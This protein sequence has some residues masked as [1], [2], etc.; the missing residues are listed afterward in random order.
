MKDFWVDIPEKIKNKIP[1]LKALLCPS[2][3]FFKV[4][5]PL[6]LL[7]LVL[8]VALDLGTKKIVTENLNF[9]LSYDQYQSFMEGEENPA[10]LRDILN[11]E[12][13]DQL[14]ILG[15]KGK[16]LKFRLIFNDR[17]IFGIG[18]NLPYL[19]FSLSLLATLFLLL[20]RWFNP[21]FA[22]PVAW[23]FIFSGALGNL[24]DKMFIKS[25]STREWVF[26]LAPQKGYVSGVVDFVESIW[27]G[28]QGF[29]SI[30]LLRFLS[31]N[32]WP[33]FNLADS[34]ISIGLVFLLLTTHKTYKQRSKKVSK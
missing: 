33:N 7:F 9:N 30:F 18:P 17:F 24:I 31:M 29:E 2:L 19:G 23:L 25:L 27:F 22:H 34:L 4:Y 28:W 14:D 6:W 5:H 11:T 12:G 26:S 16:Y 13:A 21:Y 1:R 15:E 20:Y 32:S 8:L 3:S 10:A